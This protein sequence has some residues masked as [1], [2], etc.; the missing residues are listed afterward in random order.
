[1]AQEVQHLSSKHEALSSTPQYR[2]RRRRRKRKKRRK[3][4]RRSSN[5][6]LRF[7][8]RTL[9]TLSLISEVRKQ[10]G[11]QLVKGHMSK[12]EP[13]SGDYILLPLSWSL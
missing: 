8:L 1:V 6:M 9:Y 3:R 11:E 7:A 2:R 12:N 10:R 4:G 5:H 13:R